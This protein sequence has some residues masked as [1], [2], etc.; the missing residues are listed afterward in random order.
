MTLAQS[1]RAIKPS[2]VAIVAKYERRSEGQA[3][4]E[5][6]FILGTGFAVAEGLIAT[7]DHILRAIRALPKPTFAPKGEWPIMCFMFVEV[8]ETDLGILPLDVLG[9]FQIKSH[10][11]GGAW[12]GTSIPDLGFIQVKAK[13][14][15]TV[16]IES[17][18]K[19]LEEGMELATAGYPLGR[20]TL[21]A[22]GHLHHFGPTLQT[23]VLAAILPFPR[24]RPHAFIMNIVSQG[25]Q[26]GSPVF[27]PQSGKVV[28]ILYG[29]LNEPGLTEP[30]NEAYV[31]P[32]AITYILPGPL[33]H[34]A[35][36]EAKKHAD[37]AIPNDAL[38]VQEMI[39][40]YSRKESSFIALDQKGQA[41]ASQTISLRT[42]EP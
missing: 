6:P 9:I 25:G 32:T 27:L 40:T 15:R 20:D 23:G 13:G 31:Q 5:I 21:R 12:L 37:F 28:G 22:P 18:W 8:N 10:T 36:Q 24:S 19:L 11:P 3:E 4:P 26:S 41:I 35:V 17:D 39:A 38:T 14:L 2:I 7:N 42:H 29:G 16:D 30:N 34:T 1:Y 33:I